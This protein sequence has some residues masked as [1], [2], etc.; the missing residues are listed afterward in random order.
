MVI[1]VDI[2]GVLCNLNNYTWRH[3][4]S[5][6]KE[7]NISFKFNKSKEKFHEQFN[8][9]SVVEDDFWEK[10]SL[11]YAKVVKMNN[12]ANYYIQKLHNDGH[13]IVII[14]SRSF[15]YLDNEKGAK[16][17]EAV[18]KWLSKNKIYYDTI[19][20][21]YNKI[22][23]I[24]EEKV[25]VMIEDDANNIE[26]FSKVVPVII[27]KTP[28][29]KKCKGKNKILTNGWKDIYKTINKMQA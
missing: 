13:R 16:M 27:Y 8:V 7:N 10:Y 2:D 12:H 11:H 5:Y 28:A 19:Y 29:N 17:R 24:K 25:E 18:K 26:N 23:V 15:S 14:T 20:F 22:E 9:S 1:G 6:L 4:K 3:F 21:T